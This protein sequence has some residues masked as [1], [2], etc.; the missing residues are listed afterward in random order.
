MMLIM[1]NP[2]KIIILIIGIIITLLGGGAMGF[3]LA[4]YFQNQAILLAGMAIFFTILLWFGSGVEI[5]NLFRDY[6]RGV[7]E[8]PK[9]LIEHNKEERIYSPE[10]SQTSPDGTKNNIRPLKVLI[11][12]T[13]GIAR[14]CRAE[15]RVTNWDKKTISPTEAPKFLTWCNQLSN[16]PSIQK[17]IARNRDE[18]LH[19]VISD[20]RLEN[21][22]DRKDEIFAFVSTIDSI[23]SGSSGYP[24]E[25]GFGMGD[26]EIELIVTS[27][28]DAFKKSK[29]LLHVDK[30]FRKLSMEKISKI[31]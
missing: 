1:E 17:D 23:Y 2:K 19:V 29:F 8:K 6:Y 31:K 9:L 22:P 24:G 30:D 11:R 18:F 20:S 26:F 10:L 3:Y 7:F 12:N 15:L 16:I 28:N 4:L 21:L 27:E 5:L 14:N 25:Y 13:G